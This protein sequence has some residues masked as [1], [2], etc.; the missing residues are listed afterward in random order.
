MCVSSGDVGISKPD[1]AIFHMALEQ[2][3]CTP[4]EDAVMIGDRLD[5]DVRPAKALGFGTVRILQGPGRFQQPRDD[6]EIPD[7][8]VAD[9]D[10]LAE[11]LGVGA[12]MDGRD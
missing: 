9:L 4:P 11:A 6:A 12:D 1:P 10:E 7:A 8:T 5:N 2:A 3:G